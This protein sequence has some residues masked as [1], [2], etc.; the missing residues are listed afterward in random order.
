MDGKEGGKLNFLLPLTT[1]I[2]RSAYWALPPRSAAKN[3]GGYYNGLTFVK[4]SSL[5]E[6]D[7]SHIAVRN[8]VNEL[9]I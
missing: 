9:N 6:A 8:S 5:S 3:G 1:F 7:N 4:Q 2:Q